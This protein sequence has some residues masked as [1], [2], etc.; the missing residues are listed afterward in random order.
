MIAPRAPALKSGARALPDEEGTEIREFCAGVTPVAARARS[1]MKRGLK[2][3]NS[4][5]NA[6]SRNARARSPMKRG[7]K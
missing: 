2:S 5:R 3:G 7:L 4:Y 6:I 1:P